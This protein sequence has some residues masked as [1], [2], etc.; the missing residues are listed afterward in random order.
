MTTTHP[1]GDRAAPKAQLTPGTVVR[2]VVQVVAGGT[3]R[4]P[5]EVWVLMAG[6]V[7]LRVSRT[8]WHVTVRLVDFAMDPDDL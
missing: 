3:G 8:I 2:Q 7:A 6:A 1:G 4:T 5:A